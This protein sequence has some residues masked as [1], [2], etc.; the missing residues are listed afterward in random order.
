MG[1]NGVASRMLFSELYKIMVNKYIVTYVGFKGS[2]RR[3]RP[4]PRVRPWT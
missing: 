3:N 1:G 2:D 4:S